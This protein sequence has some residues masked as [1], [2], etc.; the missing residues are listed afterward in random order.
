[1]KFII[2]GMLIIILIII[3]VKIVV[4]VPTNKES[5]EINSE[6]ANKQQSFVERILDDI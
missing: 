3:V 4:A 5:K 2:I 6:E 1:M